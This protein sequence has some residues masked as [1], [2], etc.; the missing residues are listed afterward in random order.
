M[1]AVQFLTSTTAGASFLLSF[2]LV[3]HPQKINIVAN[4]WL[5]LFIFTLGLSILEI[6]LSSNKFRVA[7]ENWFEAIGITRFL[8]APFLYISIKHFTSIGHKSRLNLYFHLLP[9]FIVLLF[10]MPFF[11]TGKNV[12]LSGYFAILVFFIL[13]ITLPLQAIVYWVL[14]YLELQKHSLNLKSFS[15]NLNG[16]NLSWIR[17]FLF[18]LLGLILLWFNMLYFNIRILESYT[19]FCYLIAIF[20]LS[21]FA[22]RQGEIFPFT[23]KELADL[24]LI[25]RANPET[26]KKRKRLTEDRTDLLNDQLK[27]LI[28]IDK[29]FLQNELSLPALAMKLGA[30][31]NEVSFLINETYGENF[32][33]FI[34]KYRI[35]EA[36]FLLESE[37][38]N[39]LNILGIAFQSGFNSKTT[40]NTAF[41]KITGKP[42]T[43]YIAEQRKLH[44]IST[45]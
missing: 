42:P 13:Q 29:I 7:H 39:K 37:K 11:L 34:N 16:T 20:S 26:S 14:S 9:F 18:A 12:A 38:Y 22:L 35:Q 33:T 32:Y 2:L 23:S 19:P 8:I 15:S 44:S 21:Y 3:N 31:S 25:I 4:R 41:K 24:K 30:S 6:S 5:G 10:R 27:S 28:E 43:A 36:M 17:F 45:Q 40:F 1:I